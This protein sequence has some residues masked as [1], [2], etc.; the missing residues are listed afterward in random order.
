MKPTF[1][2]NL[3][4]SGIRVVKDNCQKTL[5]TGSFMKDE[6]YKHDQLVISKSISQ[7]STGL[8]PPSTMCLAANFCEQLMARERAA[9]EF[10]E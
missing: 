7:I 10:S 1:S 9:A 3:T 4:G 2:P 5:A 8:L 6:R